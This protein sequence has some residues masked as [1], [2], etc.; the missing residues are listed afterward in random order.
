MGAAGVKKRVLNYLAAFAVAYLF[1]ILLVRFFEN[2]FIFFPNFPGR[3]L[4][5]W[6]P[7]GLAKE[8]V[9]LQTSDGVKL[10]AWWVPA[11]GAE[12]TFVCFHGNAA[13]IANR[14]DAYAFLRVLPANVLAV[15]YR[16]YG[17]SEGSPSEPGI[18]LDAQA[19]HDYLTRQRGI[20]PQRIIAHGQSLGTAV[21]VDLATQ[22]AL[23]GLVLEAPFPS[24]AAVARRVY[25]FLPGLTLVMRV[26]FDTA[27]K[28]AALRVPVLVA[29]CRQDPVIAFSFGEQVF[30]AANEPKRFFAADAYCHEEIGL[31]APEKYAP[32]LREFLI[33]LRP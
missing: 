15:E 22:R 27:R 33:S 23:G 2:S 6:D 18:Y 9:W 7:P 14:A 1:I 30:A 29:H 28:L 21:A 26:K 11:A 13:N 12:F 4:G 32:A 16:G 5:E 20:A 8:D 24:A 25:F 10:H 31:V 17:K 19:A 3:L